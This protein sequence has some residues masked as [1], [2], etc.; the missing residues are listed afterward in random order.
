MHVVGDGYIS[1][2]LNVGGDFTAPNIYNKSE[3]DSLLSSYAPTIAD[4]SLAIAKTEGLNDALLT[5]ASVSSL[6][7]GLSSKQDKIDSFSTLNISSIDTINANV[8]GELNACQT[9]INVRSSSSSQFVIAEIGSS[10]SYCQFSHGHHIDTYTRGDDTGRSLYLNH[11]STASV[12][13]G[14]GGLGVGT[15]SGSYMLNVS[16]T[17]RFSWSVS[18]NNYI[19]TSD[20]R[21]KENVEDLAL[22]ECVR[23]VKAVHPKK[24]NRIDMDGAPRIGYL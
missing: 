6:V 4:G 15:D 20:Q 12:R 11:Y 1:T 9:T 16:G 24:Y 3:V 18:A 2:T 22:D 14:S 21:I 17:G 19:T 8:S 7:A 10:I 23:V 13:T 5:K